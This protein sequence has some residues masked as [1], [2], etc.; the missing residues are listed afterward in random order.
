MYHLIADYGLGSG[1]NL[2]RLS[3]ATELV[4]TSFVVTDSIGAVLRFNAM[5]AAG[6][7]VLTVESMRAGCDA[8]I[9]DDDEE[10]GAVVVEEAETE[11]AST[12][13]SI[14]KE[15]SSLALISPADAI[16]NPPE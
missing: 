9:V 6:M 16:L 15:R 7:S 3:S 2:R 8:D 12:V 4:P 11:A 13:S 1:S 14:K 5:V 10:D